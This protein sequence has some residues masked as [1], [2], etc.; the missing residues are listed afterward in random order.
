MIEQASTS[1]F[2]QE[3]CMKLEAIVDDRP[4]PHYDSSAP[5]I[6]LFFVA[7]CSTPPDLSLSTQQL[8]LVF[9]L[10]SPHYSPAFLTRVSN[11]LSAIN[12]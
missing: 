12:I 10:L 3:P 2:A 7:N 6:I 9:D 5:Y 4:A 11:I 1:V 8:E